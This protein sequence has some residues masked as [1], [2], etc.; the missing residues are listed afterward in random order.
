MSELED[1]FEFQL[2]AMGI[3]YVREYKPWPERKY[4]YD[5][6]L[7]DSCIAVDIQGGIWAK[8]ASGHKTGK[9][10]TTDSLKGCYASLTGWRAFTFP[11][12]FIKSGQALDVIMSALHPEDTALR[13][14][15][16]RF[17]L[18]IK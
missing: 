12:Q 15:V 11:P 6:A 10:I 13:A 3:R 17:G 14:K 8:G 5:F 16:M 9:G 2:K 7:I 4:R 1:A 18:R